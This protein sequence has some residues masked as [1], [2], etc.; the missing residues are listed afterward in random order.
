MIQRFKVYCSKLDMQLFNLAAIEI[1]WKV[2]SNM[3]EFP[4]GWI[5][6]IL[7]T[8]VSLL[9]NIKTTY[10]STHN[11]FKF[12]LLFLLDAFLKFTKIKFEFMLIKAAS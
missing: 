6:L 2:T 5:F 9:R 1:A 3:I 7:L 10:R 4:S 8:T 11:K 12:D